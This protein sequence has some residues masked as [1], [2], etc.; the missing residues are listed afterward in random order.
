MEGPR[1]DRGHFWC[2]NCCVPLAGMVKLQSVKLDCQR[3]A[4]FGVRRFPVEQ[5]RSVPQQVS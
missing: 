1:P 5:R 4:G 2:S 3:T